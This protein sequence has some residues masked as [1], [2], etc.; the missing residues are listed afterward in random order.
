MLNNVTAVLGV[1]LGVAGVVLTVFYGIRQRERRKTWPQVLS[2]VDRLWRDLAKEGFPVERI[3]TFANG[4]LIVAD[5]I[6]I[7]HAHTTPV[8]A[9]GVHKET[10]PGSTSREVVLGDFPSLNPEFFA[11]K[12]V[13]VLDDV[14]NSGVTLRFV[15]NYLCNELN[16][17]E[18]NIKTA[19]L[20]RRENSDFRP[21]W[22]GFTY[23]N[24][25]ALPWGR[26]PRGL[27]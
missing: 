7:R 27:P 22:F 10:A 14:I 17:S 9:L 18:K 24:H 12:H 20:G 6:H 26:T 15:R 16:V 1:L 11:G 5:L 21:D 23:A 19:V 3:V 2:I 4:G 13:L 25:V 8:C